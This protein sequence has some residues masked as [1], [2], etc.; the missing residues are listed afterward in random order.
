MAL[1]TDGRKLMAVGRSGLQYRPTVISSLPLASAMATVHRFFE[2]R[3]ATVDPVS[4][5]RTIRF[6]RGRRWVGRLTWLL[7]WWSEKWP[8]QR[9]TATFREQQQSVVVSVEYDVMCFFALITKPNY[10]EREVAELRSEGWLRAIAHG[11]DGNQGRYAA[12]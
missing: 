11:D 9:I 12:L 4:S 2:Q 8:L 7:P 3:G 5:S 1:W 6:V 10:L